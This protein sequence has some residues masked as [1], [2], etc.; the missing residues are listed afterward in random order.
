[1]VRC[2]SALLPQHK[3]CL[4]SRSCANS[5]S[6]ANVNQWLDC[7]PSMVRSVNPLLNLT[8]A[9][10]GEVSG[11]DWRTLATLSPSLFERTSKTARNLCFLH[12]KCLSQTPVEPLAVKARH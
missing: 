12:R 4:R 6:E 11:E 10:S 7:S 2:T 5:E 1:M 8:V 3:W 9:V